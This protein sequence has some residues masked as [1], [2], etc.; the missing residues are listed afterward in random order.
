MTFKFYTPEALAQAYKTACMSELQALKPGNVHVFADGHGMTIDD[1]IKSADVTAQ[2]VANP[3]LSV[4][5]RIYEAVRAT[6]EAVGQNTNLGMLL[7]CVPL[8]QAAQLA[9]KSS[10]QERFCHVLTH[11]DVSDAQ[12]VAKAIVL[13]NPAGLGA[14]DECDVNTQPEITLLEMMQIAQHKDRIAWNYA[15][16]F[17]DVFEFG[18]QRY[19]DAMTKWDNP[20]WSATALYL[21]LLT[22]YPDTHVMRKYGMETA[23][24]LMQEALDMEAIYWATDNPKLVQKHLLNW[25]ASLKQRGI[26]P[27]TSADFV[28]GTLLADGMERG[29]SL[30][31]F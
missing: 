25:D 10:L 11:L 5:Q 30:G 24:L 3:D 4:G 21:G 9:M 20:A 15:H 6:K 26:N 17:A 2:I 28:V 12:W 22:Q 8:I 1:F 31:L 13:A 23:E 27:G 19:R 18:L 7:L 14:D 16:Q 29:S